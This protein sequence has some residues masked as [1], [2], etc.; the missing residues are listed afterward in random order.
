MPTLQKLCSPL[1]LLLV[2]WAC[3]KDSGETPQPLPSTGTVRLTFDLMA[4]EKPLTLN[5]PFL[6]KAED[7]VSI[8]KFKYYVSNV[9][10][11][12]QQTGD[13]YQVPDSYYLITAPDLAATQIVTLVGVPVGTYDQ[14]ELAIGVDNGHNTSIDQV[15]D[16]DPANDMA[17]NWH[18]GYKF[19][20]L[21]GIYSGDTARN[22]PVTYHIGSDL[23]Y[24]IL[25]FSLRDLDLPALLVATQDTVTVV[26][27]TNV[28][29][30]FETPHLIDLDTLNFAMFEPVTSGQIADNYADGMLRV[31]AVENR[32]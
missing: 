3:E 18:T 32:P 4:G 1:A 10:V 16:L 2:L 30:V 11:R 8:R 20:L 6:T 21:E 26:M 13:F 29:E 7:T 24:R 31:R 22:R 28:L 25:T 17:W 23:N 5:S 27:E 14:L 9:K 15:G 19:L 12:N